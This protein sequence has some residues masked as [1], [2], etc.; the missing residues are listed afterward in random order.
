MLKLKVKIQNIEKCIFNLSVV[1]IIIISFQ[2]GVCL[3]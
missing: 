1:F 2:N 3:W